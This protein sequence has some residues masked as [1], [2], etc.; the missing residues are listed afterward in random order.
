[1]QSEQAQAMLQDLGFRVEIVQKP[2]STIEVGRVITTRPVSG[3]RAAEGSTV[4]L[5]VSTGPQQ[6]Q[7]PRLAGL[8]QNQA[9]AALTSVALTLDPNVEQEPST[10]ADAGK[11]V[12]QQPSPGVNVNIDS[13]VQI[14]VGSGPEQVRVPNVVGQTIDVAQPNLEGVGFRVAV[15]NVDSQQPR[16]EVVSTSPAGGAS[17]DRGATVTVRVSNGDQVTMP[18]LTG[19][20]VSQALDS[21]R[22]AGWQGSNSNL[23]QTQVRTLEPDKVGRIQTQ[24]QP[25]GSQVSRTGTVSVGVGVLG[26]PG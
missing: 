15:E 8:D 5:E 7:V 17:T 1:V 24:A 14:T 16:G 9:N 13:G 21:L 26:I 23:T 6:V 12:D 25:A 10:S 22:G 4:N 19:Q 2:D 20:T 3:A 18:D 11:V